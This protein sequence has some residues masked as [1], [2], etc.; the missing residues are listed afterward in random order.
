MSAKG[1]E[2]VANSHSRYYPA[3][4]Q[5]S[6]GSYFVRLVCRSRACSTGRSLRAGACLERG[7]SAPVWTPGMDSPQQRKPRRSAGGAAARLRLDVRA[8]RVPFVRAMALA[9]T[10]DPHAGAPLFQAGEPLASARVAV[11]L[12]HGR[13]GDAERTL[14]MARML[15]REKVCF[16]APAARGNSWYPQRFLAPTAA[17]EPWLSS[18]LEL[19]TRVVARAVSAG[20]PRERIVLGGFSQG[21]CLSLEW[22]LRAGGRL[23]GVFA[24]SGA[25]IGEPGAPRPQDRDLVGTPV[26]LGC[27]DADSHIPLASVQE[28]AAILRAHGASL[29]ERIYPGLGHI[30]VSDEFN[31]ASR[32]IQA[33]AASK[34][35]TDKG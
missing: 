1:K 13:G 4:P 6:A 29:T 30:I 15:P 21:A 3:G 35:V 32:M 5:G 26:F 19:I 25:L 24:L 8:P 14:E 33:V 17:N 2:S 12:L 11:L 28:S 31:A 10:S 20:L 27:G 18:A 16:L 9:D 22:A 7:A 34:R 23:G